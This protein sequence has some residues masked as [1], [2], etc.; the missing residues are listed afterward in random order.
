MITLCLALIEWLSDKEYDLIYILD[1][2]LLLGL[3]DITNRIIE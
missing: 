2:I 1:I 3:Y